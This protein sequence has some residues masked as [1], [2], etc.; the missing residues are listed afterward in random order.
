MTLTL[1]Q[2]RDCKERV[3]GK[4]SQIQSSRIRSALVCARRNAQY[5]ELKF[6]EFTRFMLITVKVA[7]SASGPT[8]C[9]VNPPPLSSSQNI[10]SHEKSPTIQYNTVQP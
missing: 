7:V 9:V 1:G 4:A 8:G 6:L 3:K 10:Q 5:R 2:N